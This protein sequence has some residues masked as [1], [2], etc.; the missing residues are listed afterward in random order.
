MFFGGWVGSWRA[1]FCRSLLLN[2]GGTGNAAADI[3]R[4]PIELL[5]LL[6]GFGSVS[7]RS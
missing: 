7:V 4:F 5:N 6:L 3:G 1:P 2:S